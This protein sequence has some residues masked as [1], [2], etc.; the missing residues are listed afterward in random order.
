MNSFYSANISDFL[1][2]PVDSVLGNLVKNNPF[3]LEDTQRNSWIEEISIFKNILEEHQNGKI[4]FEYAIPR[5]GKRVDVVLLI[6]GYVFLIEFKVGQENYSSGYDQVLDYA[7]DLKYFHKASRDIPIIPILCATKAENIEHQ[8]EHFDDKIYSVIK[9]NKQTLGIILNDFLSTNPIATNSLENWDDSEYAPTP[10]IIEAAQALYSSHG[11]IEITRNDAGAQNISRTASAIDKIIT[12]S[13]INKQKSIC[14]ITGV[15]G[16]GKTLAGLNIANSRHNFQDEEHAV[17]LSGNG[18]LVDVLQEALVRDELNKKTKTNKI[19]RKDAERKVKAFIQIIHHFRDACLANKEQPPIEKVAIFDEAQRAWNKTQTSYFMA[20]KKG[21]DDFDMSE[22]EFLI[23]AMDR[24]QD[25][26]VIICLVGG[27][28]EI[29]VGEAGISEWFSALKEKYPHWNVYVSKNISDS[30]YGLGNETN[31]LFDN[32]KITNV[33]EL[34]LNVSIR[35][36]RSENLASLVKNI[37]DN[38]IDEAKI[39][40]EKI[41][42][43]YPILL[44]RDINKAKQWLRTKARG[45]ER[46][47]IV[48]SSNSRRLKPYGLFSQLKIYAPDWF[49]NTKDDISSSYFLEDVATEFDVQGLEV[50]WTCVA[51]DADMQYRNGLWTYKMFRGKNWQNL[52]DVVK[53]AYKRNAYRVL[54][55]RARQGMVIFVPP[56]NDADKTHLSEFYN[57]TY[58]FFKE[59]GFNEI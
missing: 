57:E 9:A 21:I 35:S 58:N 56:G 18:P 30:E 17:F 33:P 31:S 45:T 13:K 24:H 36:F 11:I 44:T 14:F 6:N 46:F 26:A 43:K 54:L 12:E 20:R 23:S 19:T 3:S 32:F 53:I 47:G 41:K 15:P 4:L 38:K 49:L 42:D 48:A 52:S 16:S 59:I 10:T 2:T 50:D 27:G 28:Q 5:M 8:F 37:L 29:N 25:W 34:H 55:T 40:Y 1:Q 51:W 39:A 22:P 7:L